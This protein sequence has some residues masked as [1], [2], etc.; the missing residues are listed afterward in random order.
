M[1]FH[2]SIYK[3]TNNSGP[4]LL[5]PGQGE[6]GLQG[7]HPL[8]GQAPQGKEWKYSFLLSYVGIELHRTLKK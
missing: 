4:G 5:A 7:V 2:S 1:Q 3:N 6:G 8:L